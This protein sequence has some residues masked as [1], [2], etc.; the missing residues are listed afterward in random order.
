[1]RQIKKLRYGEVL[2]AGRC[3]EGCVGHL[4]KIPFD[5]AFDGLASLLLSGEFHCKAATVKPQ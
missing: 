1:M 2:A 5:I 3:A 4:W